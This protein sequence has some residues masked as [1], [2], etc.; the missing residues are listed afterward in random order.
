LSYL[1]LFLLIC[2]VGFCAKREEGVGLK[3]LLIMEV[4]VMN[5]VKK[6]LA[7][8]LAAGVMST[9]H[10]SAGIMDDV[11]N[12]AIT[13]KPLATGAASCLAFWVVA[14]VRQ[15]VLGE[16]SALALPVV[17]AL[18]AGAGYYTNIFLGSLNAGNR[19]A[20]GAQLANMRPQQLVSLFQRNRGVNANPAP[21]PVPVARPA[22]P[23]PVTLDTA[24]VVVPAAPAAALAAQSVAQPVV[25]DNVSGRSATSSRRTTRSQTRNQS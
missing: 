22:V 15:A 24:S 1:G 21:A 13:H 7:I 17:S 14:E 19:P 12:F 20:Q 16:A 3:G 4:I 2:R 23:A 9:A 8:A 6:S 5:Y 10:V 11:K 25:P 18:A